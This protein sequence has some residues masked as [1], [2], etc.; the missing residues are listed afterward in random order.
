MTSRTRRRG[1]SK[2]VQRQSSSKKG[3]AK[4][5]KTERKEEKAK[6]KA[7]DGEGVKGEPEEDLSPEIGSAGNRGR[8]GLSDF[9]LIQPR[10][11]P[12]Q[13]TSL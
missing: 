12:I 5:V 4:R 3:N 9:C 6:R 7:F 1:G 11:I 2:P 13:S 10:S 8:V